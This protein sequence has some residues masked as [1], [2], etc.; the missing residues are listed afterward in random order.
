MTLL[1]VL[2]CAVLCCAALRCAVLC[3]THRVLCQKLLCHMSGCIV[4]YCLV[5]LDWAKLNAN[6]YTQYKCQYVHWCS[7]FYTGHATCSS[8]NA[9]PPSHGMQPRGCCVSLQSEAKQSDFSATV[10]LELLGE[11]TVGI[12]RADGLKCARYCVQG[13]CHH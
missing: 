4:Q 11:V 13:S 9:C 5:M 1:P 8:C 12:T 3:F 10:Q 2:C 6:R 7:V